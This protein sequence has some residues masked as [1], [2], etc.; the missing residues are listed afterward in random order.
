LTTAELSE[1]RISMKI[2]EKMGQ[3]HSLHIP[4]SKEADWIFNT[5]NR[6]FNNI[7]TIMN[8]IR[9][10]NSNNNEDNKVLELQ[11][12]LSKVDLRREANWL[13]ELAESEAYPVVFCHNDLQEGNILF[14]QNNF[15]PPSLM[16]TLDEELNNIDDL[17]PM[18]ISCPKQLAVQEEMATV[19]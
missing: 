8:D 14:R 12:R 5:L 15:V 17:S 19:G 13:R 18:L 9:N 10:N 7:D 11:K 2:A 3:I 16:E 1:S 6:W 4:V